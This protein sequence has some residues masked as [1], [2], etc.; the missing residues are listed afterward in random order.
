MSG[1]GP[2]EGRAGPQA[3]CQPGAGGD[4]AGAAAHLVQGPDPLYPVHRREGVDHPRV[5][6]R[7][8][9]VRRGGESGAGRGGSA[10]A[11]R[12][13]P[14]RGAGSGGRRTELG[15]ASL[16]LTVSCGPGRGRRRRA[17]ERAQAAAAPP[18]RRRRSSMFFGAQRA[19]H[20]RVRESGARHPRERAARQPRWERQLPAVVCP[21]GGLGGRQ[22]RRVSGTQVA[23]RRA[24]PPTAGGSIGA[25]RVAPQTAPQRRPPWGETSARLR[26]GVCTCR[27]S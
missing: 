8:R 3:E 19:A 23:E 21:Q 25:S 4:G 26:G 14:G 5:P 27:W 10:C 18:R 13:G 7:R 9:R 17:Q 6:L 22:E 11:G 2:G 16:S 20:Q 1:E 12:G 24:P 15:S